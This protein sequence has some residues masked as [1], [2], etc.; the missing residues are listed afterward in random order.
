MERRYQI[1]VSSTF[2]DL[3][4]ERQAVTQALLNLNHFP[5]GMELF[6]ASN[7][8]QWALIRGVIDDS[9]YYLLVIG[10]RYGSTTE[11]G[12]SFTEKEFVYAVES[13]IPIL[14]FIH[15]EPGNLPAKKTD[16]SDAARAKLDAFREKVKTGRHV[17]FWSTPENLETRVMQAVSAETKRNPREGWVRG[18][19]SGDPVKL[20]ELRDEVG[21]LKAA[22]ARAR[23]MP[24]PGSEAY[25]QGQEVFKVLCQHR[26]GWRDSWDTVEIEVT[27]D[28]IFYELGPLLFNEASEHSMRKRLTDQI[29][30][31]D[32]DFIEKP[33]KEHQV[34]VDSFETIKIQLVALG[35]MQKS[36]R[37]H[38]PSDTATYW[39]ATPFGEQ[40]IMKLRALKKGEKK[41]Y[42]NDEPSPPPV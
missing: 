12:I 35:L 18:N 28:D 5:A 9:D 4:A 41:E 15:E 13:G 37:K 30:M 10:G 16:Q 7:E 11:E 33:P 19:L 32:D 42:R 24:P 17:K 36:D 27:W 1:F 20:N 26:E 40:Y 2:Q 3:T 38:P 23:T 22:L 34:Y 25:A 6:P 14:A 31:Y 21:Q 29:L 39:Q 8:D